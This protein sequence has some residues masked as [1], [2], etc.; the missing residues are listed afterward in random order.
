MNMDRIELLGEY[1]RQ[2]VFHLLDAE[3]DFDGVSAG[4]IAADMEREFYASV[5]R[6]DEEIVADWQAPLSRGKCSEKQGNLL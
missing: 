4:R 5:L 6:L 3:P 2:C 1:I